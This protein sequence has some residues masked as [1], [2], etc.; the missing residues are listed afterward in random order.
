MSCDCGK[1][2][3]HYRTLGIG[4]GIPTESEIQDAYREAIKQ[5]HPDLYENFA[6][7]RADAEERFKLIQVAYRELKEHNSI[8]VDSPAEIAPGEIV[9]EKPKDTPPVSFDG[10]PGCLVAPHFTPEAE[11]VIARYAKKLGSAVAIVD[12]T[13][14][15]SQTRSYA[16][17]FL[18]ADLGIMVRDAQNI[19][20]LLWY[21]DLGEINL[22]RRQEPS[23]PGMWQSL[24]GGI[25]GS[26]PKCML[27]IVRNNGALFYSLADHV[28]DSVK[29]AI[30]DFLQLKKNQSHP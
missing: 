2:R 12:L 8:A 21:K 4:Y 29:T 17:F 27:Q 11:E 30:H 6:S 23:K 1:C 9:P 26:Q 24:V 15:R 13:G 28:E 7:L 25:S 3:E 16:Q 20:S 5:W 18:L 14:S 19:V 22:I 10:A